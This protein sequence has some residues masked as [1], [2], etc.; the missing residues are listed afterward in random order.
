MPPEPV[1]RARFRGEVEFRHEADALATAP[2]DVVLVMRGRPR[3]LVFACPEGCGE[4]LT[5]NLD[6]QA[7]RAWTLFRNK[8]GLT[9]FPSVWREGGCRSHF[10]LWHDTLLWFGRAEDDNQE[11]VDDTDADLVRQ[12][13]ESLGSNFEPYSVLAARLSAIPWDV[14][15]VCRRLVSKGLAEHGRGE[16]R[17][18][19]RKAAG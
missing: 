4:R 14:E 2:G 19:F 8:R 15:R 12:V 7:G 16:R 13:L 18:H 6:P 1:R 9:L 10:I 5:I 3:S 17:D 11:P